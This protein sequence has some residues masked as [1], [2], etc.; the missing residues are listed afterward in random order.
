[1][2][3]VV[4]N[5]AA[6]VSAPISAAGAQGVAATADVDGVFC[7][8][9][10]ASSVRVTLPLYWRGRWLRCQAVTLDVDILFGTSSVSVAKD[11]VST[12]SGNVATL[13]A[14]TGFTIAAGT[15]VDF[16]IPKT[17]LVTDFAIIASGTTGFFKM[18]PSDDVHVGS[19]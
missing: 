9:T 6:A 19:T 12:V 10:T 18:Y 3:S 2:S 7:L 17:S 15:Y 8:A 5:K 4:L 1:M 16:Y 14:A 11:Q 13:N